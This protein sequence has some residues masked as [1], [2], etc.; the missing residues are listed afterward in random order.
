[1]VAG[2]QECSHR[3]VGKQLPRILQGLVVVQETADTHPMQ[4]V[5]L[6]EHNVE[7]THQEIREVIT[8]H[9]KQQLILIDG[10]GLVGKDEHE[11]LVA[12]STEFYN[13]GRVGTKCDVSARPDVTDVELAAVQ[14]TAILHTFH[15]H[16]RQLADLAV[17]VFLNDCFEA[18]DTAIAVAFVQHAETLD[19]QKFRAVLTQGETIS[20]DAG[21]SFHDV[22]SVGL[23]GF[24]GGSIQ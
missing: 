6:I 4:P 2:L 10:V 7:V 5:V 9:L 15:N 17:G 1:M 19:K 13:C 3:L 12:L 11:V 24:V 14:P 8:G 20:R 22:V 21:V 16:A 18:L 23:K